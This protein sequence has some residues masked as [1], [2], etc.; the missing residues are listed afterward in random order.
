MQKKFKC[1]HYSKKNSSVFIM[2]KKFKCF[3]Y[4]KN[5]QPLKDYQIS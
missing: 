5:S 1:F 4:E 2:Q 3:H